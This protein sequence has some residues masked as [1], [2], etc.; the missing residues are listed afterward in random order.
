LEKRPA[1]SEEN[2]GGENGAKKAKLDP[3]C[4]RLLFCGS[5][6]WEL[7]QKVGKLKEDTYYSKQ[8]IYEP[9]FIS[10]IKELRV[11]HVSSSPDACHVVIVDEDGTAWSW[12]NNEFGQLGQGDKKH[13]RLPNKI[14]GTGPD[15][16]V[17][18][19]VAA[20]KKHTLL[21]TS[22]GEVLACGDNT[23]G[24]CAQ[25]EMKSKTVAV[26]SKAK[27]EVEMCD[28]TE[29]LTPTPINYEGPPIVKICSGIDYNLM[30]DVEGN[31]WTF[32]NQEFGKCGT[33][34]DGAYNATEAKVKMRYSGIS[35]PYQLSRVFERD[36]KSKKIKPLQMGRIKNIAA[37]SHHAAMVDEMSRV[38]T[39]GAGDY[40]R[41]GHNDTTDTHVPTWVSSLDHPRGKIDDVFCGNIC[42]V[43]VG[44]TVNRNV[45]LAGII[46]PIKREANMNPK[47]YHD[48]GGENM[49]DVGFFRKGWN[50]VGEDGNVVQTNTG[51]CYGELGSGEKFRTQGVPKKAKEFEYPHILK[52]GTGSNHCVYIMRDCEEADKEE[53]EEFDDLDQADLEYKE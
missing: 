32:G 35:V 23:E 25:G 14:A 11:K 16:K 21:L 37:G 31:A 2:G 42:T 46:D 4:G 51:P 7:M 15:G 40:G 34:T 45:Y 30:L 27:E 9:H 17:I 29:I 47:I 8:N 5:T 22:K 36:P 53:L 20:S 38:F 41:T 13:R 49:A 1:E 12:G 10:S 50:Y 39:W 48:F 33:G 19:A 18:V 24:Q 28:V 44:K 26:G 6:N 52:V 3:E 43:M